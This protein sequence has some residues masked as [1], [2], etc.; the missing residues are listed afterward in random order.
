MG[1]SELDERSRHLSNPRSWDVLLGVQ[2]L[3][4]ASSSI[5]RGSAQ[6]CGQ[7]SADFFR[8]YIGQES[9]EDFRESLGCEG[10]GYTTSSSEGLDSY[11]I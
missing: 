8:I 10:K 11:N 1:L 4:E 7:M 2:Y 5:L 3:V 6:D 9:P